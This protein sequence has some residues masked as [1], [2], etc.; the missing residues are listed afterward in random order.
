MPLGGDFSATGG[1]FS[2]ATASNF[3]SNLFLQASMAAFPPPAVAGFAQPVMHMPSFQQPFTPTYFQAPSPL[4]A[5]NDTAIATS[6]RVILSPGSSLGVSASLAIPESATMAQVNSRMVAAPAMP[7]LNGFVPTLKQPVPR[8]T[9]KANRTARE[10]SSAVHA[11]SDSAPIIQE[12]PVAVVAKA[13]QSVAPLAASSEPLESVERKVAADSDSVSVQSSS[14]V[15]NQQMN[16]SLSSVF[17]SPS[18]PSE[19]A[20]TSTAVVEPTTFQEA[21]SPPVLIPPTPIVRPAPTAPPAAVTEAEASASVATTPTDAKRNA[22]TPKTEAHEVPP[23][24]PAAR[25]PPEHRPHSSG[26][27][28]SAVTRTSSDPT[29]RQTAVKTTSSGKKRGRPKNSTSLSS[30]DNEDAVSQ[31]ARVKPRNRNAVPDDSDSD[32]SRHAYL[33]NG[34]RLLFAVVTWSAGP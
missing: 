8:V 21:V 20:P 15:G 18:Q 5:T 32:S 12:A 7:A 27:P 16:V 31:R 17:R 4:P 22:V 9:S 23:T 2:S 14:P 29:H 25:V 3:R 1:A 33:Y 10:I 13:P 19:T 30:S 26:T 6:G 24:T 28:P 34:R 11:Q